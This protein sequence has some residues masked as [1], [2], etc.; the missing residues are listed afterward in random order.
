MGQNWNRRDFLA[1]MGV[2]GLV[3]ASGLPGCGG[4]PAAAAPGAWV[5]SPPVRDD[6]FFLQLSDTHWGYEGE[7]N[8][9]AAGTLEHA[10]ATINAVDV[11]PDF[12]VFTGD[13]TH[14]TGDAD[15]RSD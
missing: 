14:V 13:L 5:P 6:F 11:R 7:A 12:V 9:A 10:V 1:L 3:F 8:P 2:G 15:K 4:S